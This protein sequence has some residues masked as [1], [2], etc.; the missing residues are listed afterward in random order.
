MI[1]RRR[2]GNSDGQRLMHVQVTSCSDMMALLALAS[3]RPYVDAFF[4]AVMVMV[5]DEKLKAAR[6]GILK[7]IA[8]LCEQVADFG[9]LVY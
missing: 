2:L 5:E 8:G 3:L 4:A 1:E 6:L 7:S 9:K